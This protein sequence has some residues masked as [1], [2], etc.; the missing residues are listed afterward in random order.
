MEEIRNGEVETITLKDAYERYDE[1]LNDVFE[2]NEELNL[3]GSVVFKETDLEMYT[4]GFA[5]FCVD[6]T[7]DGVIVEDL[8]NVIE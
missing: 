5:D 2:S 7:L 6:L 4:R 1:M 3:S 8:S